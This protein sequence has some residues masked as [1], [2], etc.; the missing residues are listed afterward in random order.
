MELTLP[1]PRKD[2]R[3][4][5]LLGMVR[6]PV[7]LQGTT[8]CAFPASPFHL[9]LSEV[10][11]HSPA[12]SSLYLPRGTEHLPGARHC[13]WHE[14]GK[15]SAS[16]RFGLEVGSRHWPDDHPDEYLVTDGERCAERSGCVGA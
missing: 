2:G 3:A 1:L 15:G 13:S 6:G 16:W 10:P 8:R 4:N 7:G 11:L 12:H 9:C 5:L 14:G